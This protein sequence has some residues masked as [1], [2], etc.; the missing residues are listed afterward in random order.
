MDHFTHNII[1]TRCP[2][3]KSAYNVAKNLFS[4]SGNELRAITSAPPPDPLIWAFTPENN[5]LFNQIS[6]SSGVERVAPD[7]WVK[8]GHVAMQY[9]LRK[10]SWSH[11]S[12]FI[13]HRVCVC[14]CAS[15]LFI[16]TSSLLFADCFLV[17]YYPI[18]AAL[19]GWFIFAEKMGTKYWGL[20]PYEVN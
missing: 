7:E 4:S 8:R 14:V 10:E 18:N 3:L 1:R 9:T 12:T 5:L 19:N 20:E 11:I 17:W 13:A 16:S 2:W 15:L 6:D